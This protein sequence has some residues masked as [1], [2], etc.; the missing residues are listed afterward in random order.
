MLMEKD[1][2]RL[3]ETDVKLAEGK[4]DTAPLNLNARTL[5]DKREVVV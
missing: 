4:S 1:L 3:S 2:V 5:P